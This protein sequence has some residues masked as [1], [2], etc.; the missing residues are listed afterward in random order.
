[1]LSEKSF[2]ALGRH[3]WVL[4]LFDRERRL[5]WR[6]STFIKTL[7]P[8]LEL[9]FL[10]ADFVALNNILEGCFLVSAHTTLIVHYSSEQF[11]TLPHL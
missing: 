7:L 3:Y 8:S 10:E 6:L 2:N 5:T 1:M 11:K 9:R 4:I